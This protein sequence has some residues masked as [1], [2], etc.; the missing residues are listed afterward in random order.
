M[1]DKKVI[2]R[3]W[4]NKYCKNCIWLVEGSLCPFS[5]CPTVLGWA[6]DKK[7]QEKESGGKINE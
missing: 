5:G 2:S 4:M 3:K 1:R 6:S 7:T